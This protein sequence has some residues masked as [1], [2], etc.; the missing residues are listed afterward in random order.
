MK[1]FIRVLL[2]VLVAAVFVGAADL[3]TTQSYIWV[4]EFVQNCD[5]IINSNGNKDTLTGNDT[6]YILRR[7]T[8]DP[9][10]NYYI[11][12]PKWGGGSA[13]SAYIQVIIKSYN[14]AGTLLTRYAQD[15]LSATNIDDRAVLCPLNF[16]AS[17][18]V[19]FFNFG[20]S[21]SVLLKSSRTGSAQVVI[22]PQAATSTSYITLWKARPITY[23][24]PY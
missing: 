10:Y 18:D 11:V 19:R 7:F 24:K 13:D 3:R 6:A 16:N 1:N 9:G 14:A 22:G 12:S 2:Q 20:A 15:T 5:R 8:P 23:L 21:Y 17:N 4:P